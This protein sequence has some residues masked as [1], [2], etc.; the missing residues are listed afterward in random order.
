M[1]V[2]RNGDFGG[3]AGGDWEVQSYGSGRRPVSC[4][5]ASVRVGSAAARM[6]L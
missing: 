2:K 4:R 5:K 3:A 1:E 6:T